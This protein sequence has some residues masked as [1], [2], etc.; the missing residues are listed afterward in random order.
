LLKI[1]QSSFFQRT[2][3]EEHP[4]QETSKYGEA[5]QDQQSDE[6]TQLMEH[7]DLENISYPKGGRTYPQ[8]RLNQLI[9]NQSSSQTSPQNLTPMSNQI[10]SFNQHFQHD[11]NTVKLF[12]DNE[13]SAYNAN[14]GQ[15]PS[16]ADK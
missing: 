11:T 4:I 14:T 9:Q 15:F 3:D 2:I 13:S 16:N 10:H 1:P 5:D 6:E 7:P 8:T 12:Q